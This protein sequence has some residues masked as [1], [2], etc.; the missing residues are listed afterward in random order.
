[1]TAKAPAFQFYVADYMQDTRMV[2]LAAR[3][4]WMDLL[5]AMWRSPTRGRITSSMVG[6]ARL[7]GCTVE[8]A[9]AVVDEIIESQICD[10][11]FG[12]GKVTLTNRRMHREG[13]EREQANLRQK[14]YREKGQRDSDEIM[15]ARGD[16]KVTPPSSSSTSSSN[17]NSTTPRAREGPPPAHPAVQT[18]RTVFGFDPPI[19]GQEQIEAEV[20][21]EFVIWLDVCKL[22]KGNNHDPEKVG[23]LI[24]RWKREVKKSRE[25]QGRQS[26]G[27]HNRNGSKRGGSYSDRNAAALE[28][29]FGAGDERGAAE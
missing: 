12:D 15:L 22:F 17:Y 23:N 16:A 20:T 21:E 18:Y 26:H 25:G 8:Q 27:T 1:M 6:Y 5:C 7:F 9:K 10:V 14:K 28:E 3:G 2:S 11:T 4:A 24:D 29:V 13:K 19:F